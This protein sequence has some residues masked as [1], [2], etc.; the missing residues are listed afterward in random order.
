MNKYLPLPIPGSIYGFLIMILCLQFKII[1]FEKVKDVGNFLL[2]IM[3]LM[4]IPGIVRL[5]VIWGEL[6][7]NILKII[8]IS[9][10]STVLVMV[11]T[12]KV[13]EF[14]LNKGGMKDGKPN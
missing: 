4:F 9:L 7:Q 13:T 1:K 14:I 10:L 8:V 3:P 6:S 2:D 12:G 11:T 5:M